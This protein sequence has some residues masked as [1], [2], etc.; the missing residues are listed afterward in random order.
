VIRLFG[1][2]SQV[3]KIL[4]SKYRVEE[5]SIS[6]SVSHGELFTKDHRGSVE[7]IAVSA[8]ILWSAE[9]LLFLQE[10]RRAAQDVFA[11]PNLDEA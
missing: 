8:Q 6:A 1:Q 2:E 10:W 4:V 5:Y 3:G 7:V 9:A 11:S